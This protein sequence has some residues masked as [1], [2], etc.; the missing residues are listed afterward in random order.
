MALQRALADLEL[1]SRFERLDTPAVADAQQGR[2]VLD[3]R[4]RTFVPGRVIAG[5]AFTVQAPAGSMMTL[6]KALLE[7]QP[8][9]IL[10]VDAGGDPRAGGIWGELM[11]LEACQR[12]LRGLILDG[13]ARDAAGLREVGFPVFAAGST[14]RLG[15]NLQIGLCQI[16]V[17]CGGA[18]VHPGD[19]VV[20]DDDGVV[21]VPAQMVDVTLEAAERI[22]QRDR[23]VAERLVNGERM[24]DILGFHRYIYQAE[25]SVSVL[26]EP[27]R[28]ANR[29]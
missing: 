26:S 15:T 7:A 4:I 23:E 8:G 11:S 17:S 10:V 16:A 12:G 28:G 22:R 13:A 9:E 20:A 18:P 24:A 25:A 14:P 5:R 6:Q 29:S 27:E 3:Q 1:I 21:V 19:F 2:N